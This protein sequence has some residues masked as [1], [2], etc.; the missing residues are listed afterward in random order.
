MPAEIQVYPDRDRLAL[1]TAEHFARSAAQHTAERGRFSVALAGGSTPKAAYAL[2][3]SQDFAYLD[4]R[5]IHVFW[6]DERCVSPDHPDSNYRMARQALLDHVSIPAENVHR[7]QGEIPPKLAAADYEQELYAFF[8]PKDALIPQP[9]TFDL[10]LLGMGDDGHTA[11][12]FPGS[13]G[14]QTTDHWVVA[15][16]H[17]NPPPPLVTRLSLTLPAINAADQVIFLV[18]GAKKAVRLKQVLMPESGE[19]SLPAQ[20]VQPISGQLNWLID[21]QAAALL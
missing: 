20:L 12:L 2:L 4:W 1:A 14:L 8:A 18:A 21:A 16:E 11:S 5:R 6:G 15:V 7:L 3:A 9:R 19:P 10:V 13:P 17:N